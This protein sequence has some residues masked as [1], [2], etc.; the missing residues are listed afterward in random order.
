M[1]WAKTAAGYV[2]DGS[3]LSPVRPL[4]DLKLAGQ[5]KSVTSFTAM[6]GTGGGLFEDLLT[7]RKDGTF[8]N[9][10][11]GGVSLTTT[12]DG[13][14]S[15]DV[16]GGVYSSTDRRNSGSYSLSGNT[17]TLSYG[18]GRTERMFAFLPGNK[19]DLNWLYLDGS[20]YFLEKPGQK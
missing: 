16:T 6:V 10:H 4:G 3:T 17:L 19:P 18:D 1:K 13:S 2:L 8:S 15:G 9:Q 5:Y 11:S 14:S 20:D 12:S 7:F